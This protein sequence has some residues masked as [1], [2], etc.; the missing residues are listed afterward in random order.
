VTHETADPVAALTA[1]KPPMWRLQPATIPKD[2]KESSFPLVRKMSSS[3]SRIMQEINGERK[4]VERQEEQVSRDGRLVSKVLHRGD[5][6]SSEGGPAHSK[7]FTE[8]E[9]PALNIHDRIINKDGQVKTV[10]VP[11]SKRRAAP[12]LGHMVL[13]A[14][15]EAEDDD[16]QQTIEEL[17]TYVM[18]TGDQASVVQFLQMM[19][20]EGKMSQEEALIYVDN[21]K[22][23]VEKEEPVDDIEK[24]REMVQ[25][26]KVEE[27]EEM[28]VKALRNMLEGIEKENDENDAILKINDYLEG[29]LKEGKLSRNVYNHLKEALI[30]SVLEGLQ[31]EAPS[32]DYGAH[33]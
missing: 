23:I 7:G 31:Q 15:E 28:K 17:A 8:I 25:E 30:E 22:R 12:A 5:A 27:E 24:I 18:E 11:Q 6:E 2:K 33:Y 4:E 10:S 20:E 21:I 1:L 32:M 13:D 16:Q 29:G 9:V 3:N 14:P 19:M 26:N